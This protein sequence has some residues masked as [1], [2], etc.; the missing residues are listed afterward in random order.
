MNWASPPN[1]PLMSFSVRCERT[2]L[3]YNGENLNTLFAQRRNLFRPSFHR[4]IRDILRF[5]REAPALLDRHRAITLNA[6]LREQELQ[7]GIHQPL[8]FAHGGGDLVGGTGSNGR[9]AGAVLCPVL[10]EPRPAQ[11]QRP[12]AMAGDSRRL[13]QLCRTR[14]TAPFRDRIRLSCPVE[15]SAASLQHVLIKSKWC[16]VGTFRRGDLR[17]SQR[18]GVAT[19]GRSY[20]PKSGRFSARFP[21]RKTKRYCT[22]TFGC[23]RVVGGRGRPGT[24][25]CRRNR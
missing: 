4:M 20:R 10:Q 3:E 16:P 2:G 12:A 5:N 19:A 14:L 22:P 7:P 21:I 23:C 11:R 15:R 9:N 24:I 8:H 6:Y 17:L 1:R 18:S 25:I 13:A